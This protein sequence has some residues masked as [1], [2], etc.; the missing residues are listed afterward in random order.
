MSSWLGYRNVGDQSK[1]V[2]AV[3]THSAST[4]AATDATGDPSYRVYEDETGTPILTGTMGKLD[5]ANTTGFYSEELTISS[6]NGFEAGKT[7][8]IYITATVG[9]I[10]GTTERHFACWPATINSQIDANVVQIS[11]DSGAADNLESY[12]DG[13]TPM[14]VNA[15][16]ISGDATA[17]DNL[18]AAADGTGYNLGGG[19]IVAASV[20]GAVNSVTTGVTVATNNDKTGYSLATAPPTAAAIAD[21][22]WDETLADHL[23]TGS[24]GAGL[25]AAGAAGDPWST[26]LPG[27]YGAGTAGKIVG[28]N[29]NATVSSR[30]ASADISLSGGAVTVGTINTG[31]ITA[32]SIADDAITAAKLA[33]DA[34]TDDAIAASAAGEIADAVWDEPYAGHTTAGTFGKE[35]ELLRKANF[36]TEGKVNSVTGATTTSFRTDL[37]QPNGTYDHQTIL[38]TSGNLTGESKPILSYALTNGVITLD[39]PLTEAPA[40]NDEFVL[41]PTHVHPMSIMVTEILEGATSTSTYSAGQ[42]GNILGRL[43]NMIEADGADFRYT[44]NALEQAPSGG[45]GGTTFATGNVPY[46][47]KAD[48]QFPGGVVDILVGTLLRLDLQVLDRDGN[49]INLTGAT[50]TVGV[51]NASTGATVGTDQSA[52]LSLARLGYITVDTISDWSATAGTYRL[53]VSATVGSDVIVAGPLQLIVRAR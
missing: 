23:N 50:V 18:A 4:G 43:H 35:I 41:L 39:E 36:V 42:V 51:R 32:T 2:F 37:T 7:Y 34:I 16:Q 40:L 1:L 30:L 11:G 28:D 49:A 31:V 47:V 12:T 24:T 53:T 27:A 13:T 45:G 52:S 5:D 15:I 33:T 20:S 19:Q 9:S 48:E 6:G 17:A 22:V 21:A 3:N 38:F 14:P 26:A 10:A 29:L 8:T 25:N 46:Q 44:T